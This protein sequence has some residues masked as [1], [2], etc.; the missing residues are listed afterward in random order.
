MSQSH[1]TTIGNEHGTMPGSSL[2]SMDEVDRIAPPAQRDEHI[3]FDETRMRTKRI[4]RRKGSKSGAFDKRYKRHSRHINDGS[5]I[6]YGG[7]GEMGHNKSMVIFLVNFA[8]NFF[9][10]SIDNSFH[11]IP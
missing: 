6:M 9:T 10:F 7:V 2:Q 1:V 4:G 11:V 3:I 8:S 5:L